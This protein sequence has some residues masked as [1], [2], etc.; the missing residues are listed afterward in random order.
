M[1]FRPFDPDA[2][3]WKSRQRLPHWRQSG[4]TYFV[5]SRLA[6]SMPASVLADWK[7]ERDEWLAM[8]G[9]G[10]AEEVHRL[11]EQD[12]R[13]FHRVFT[14]R[15]HRW[16]DEGHG[17]CVM[18]RPAVAAIVARELVKWHSNTCELD[19]W[20]LM[21]NHFHALVEVSADQSLSQVVQQWK[22]ASARYVN[23]EL[24]RTGPL[25][26]RES[27]DHIVRS[28]RQL[29]HFRRYIAEN[30]VRAGLGRGE[31]RLG[32][33]DRMDLSPN[34]VFRELDSESGG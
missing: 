12:R 20:I 1:P 4:V 21:P 5:T 6:D 23:R 11:S 8:R 14:E 13:E 19:T 33:G 24:G 10:S 30:P 26:Q 31:Y 2:H 28:A 16:L 29:D 34:W 17:S 9:L 18:A 15:W 27:F 22:G 25:W 7:S 32:W 3:T